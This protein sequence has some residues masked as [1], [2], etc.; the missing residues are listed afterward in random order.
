MYKILAIEDDVDI[1]RVLKKRLADNGYDVLIANEPTEGIKLART[2]K[3]DLILLDLK[4]PTGGGL[5]I[6][7]TLKMAPDTREIPVVIVTGVRRAEIKEQTFKEGACAY[8]E[9]PYDPQELLD[10]VRG[11]LSKEIGPK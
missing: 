5:S 3:P 6:L 8:I 11:V 2:E 4:L 1:T 9:K 7:R 10:I